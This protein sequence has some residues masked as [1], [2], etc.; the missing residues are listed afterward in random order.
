MMIV[1]MG[2][3]E[4]VIVGRDKEY[5]DYIVGNEYKDQYGEDNRSSWMFFENIQWSL[6]H[7]PLSSCAPHE[8]K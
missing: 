7:F 1:M 3:T 5:P 6:W 4:P 8:G 2:T